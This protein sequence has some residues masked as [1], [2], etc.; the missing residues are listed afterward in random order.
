MLA[1]FTLT[2]A[3]TLAL[4][5]TPAQAA[6]DVSLKLEIE[7]A[8]KKGLD[9]LLTQQDPGTGAFGDRFYL[10]VSRLGRARSTSGSIRSSPTGSV[11]QARSSSSREA[12]PQTPQLEVV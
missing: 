5:G 2:T 12:L 7:H 1:R 6:P 11:G 8:I 4:A 3:I 10:E 9:W